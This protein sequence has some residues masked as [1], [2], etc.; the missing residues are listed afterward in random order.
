MFD[1]QP[2]K[3]SSQIFREKYVPVNALFLL[4]LDYNKV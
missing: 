1:R 4:Q 3:G 2:A